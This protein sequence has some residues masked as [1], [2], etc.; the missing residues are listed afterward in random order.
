MELK[1]TKLQ[2]V[3]GT[4]SLV[5][6]IVVIGMVVIFSFW[7]WFSHSGERGRIVRC[8]RNLEVLG[9]TM[10]S[11]A[12]DHNDCLPAA[13]INLGNTKVSWDMDLTPYLNPTQ[14][15]PA[16]V[17]A[18]RQ[19]LVAASHLFVCPSD[20]VQH[21]G[22]P[23]SYAMAACVMAGLKWPISPECKTGV[24]LWWDKYTVLSM[25]DSDT[26]Q[27]VM[28]RPELLPEIKRSNLLAP[29]DTL[30][31][32]ELFT[33]DNLLGSLSRTRVWNVNDQETVFKGYS[34][35]IHFEKFNYLMVDGHVELL[36]GLQTGGVGN[37]LAGIWTIKA[38]D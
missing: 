11:Y 17:Y 8:A 29:A 14:T 18:K 9:Q 32:T 28:K 19:L 4:F 35:R 5:D 13:G 10:Q 16:S 22:N 25:L 12:N 30:L 2:T 37:D 38:G 20:S 34:S 23:R 21:D 31:L 36:T 7:F 6:L 15:K 33:P 3:R 1:P 26:A 27:N 24:G